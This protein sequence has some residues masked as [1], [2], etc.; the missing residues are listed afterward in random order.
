MKTKL[1]TSRGYSQLFNELDQ[2]WRV[3]R[4]ETTRVVTWAASLGDRSENADILKEPHNHY[5]F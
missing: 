1:I 3:E 4:P 5:Y 2:L